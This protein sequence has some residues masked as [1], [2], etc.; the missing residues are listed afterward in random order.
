M[1]EAKKS[2]QSERKHQPTLLGWTVRLLSIGALLALFAVLVAEIAQPNRLTEI[3]VE[4]QWDEVRMA[5]TGQV[6][7]PARVINR[8]TDPI[9]NLTVEFA[10]DGGDPARF[11]I[12]FLGE[13][14]QREVVVGYDRRPAAISFKI[15]SFEAP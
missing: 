9:A 4:P 1:T 15:V 2:K 12:A 6:L 5:D 13:S 10:R 11:E 3:A 14:E 8:G 7:V